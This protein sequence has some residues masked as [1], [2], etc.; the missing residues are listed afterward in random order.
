ML[1]GKFLKLSEP[2]F[3]PVLTGKDELRLASVYAKYLVLHL[4]HGREAANRDCLLFFSSSSLCL[5][6]NLC[7][8]PLG[9]LVGTDKLWL[10]W[11]GVSKT[12]FEIIHSCLRVTG[13]AY[14]VGVKH[15]PKDVHALIP[16]NLK[17]CYLIGKRTLHT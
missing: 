4:K 2:Q 6:Q 15:G 9:R 7:L 10:S 16:W 1:L 17:M 3:S 5:S 13:E 11:E 12:I 8:F 14:M